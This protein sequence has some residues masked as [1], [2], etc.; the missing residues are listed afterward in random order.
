MACSLAGDEGLLAAQSGAQ[1]LG[2]AEGTRHAYVLLKIRLW[3]ALPAGDEG[4]LATQP[5]ARD[6]GTAGEARHGHLLPSQRQE[7]VAQAAHIVEVHSV[8]AMK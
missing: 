1:V 2:S 6:Q 4:L 7:A 5:G 8:S 3:P